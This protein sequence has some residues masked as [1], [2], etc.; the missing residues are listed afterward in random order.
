MQ[1]PNG[2]EEFEKI[3][4]DIERK[5]KS[6]YERRIHNTFTPDVEDAEDEPI[7]DINH[8]QVFIYREKQLVGFIRAHIKKD[9]LDLHINY[10]YVSAENQGKGYVGEMLSLLFEYLKSVGIQT[11]KTVSLDYYADS[12]AG[13]IAYDKGISRYGYKSN[14]IA[15]T[16][17]DLKE[18]GFVKKI[19]EKLFTN[20]MS[21]I[22]EQYIGK[23][24]KRKPVEAIEM[25]I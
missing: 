12:E 14:D 15:Y 6:A 13:W 1:K 22:Y 11:N 9:I 8:L 4:A 7:K 25:K 20:S 21:W 16:N 2:L 5:D 17:E 18:E 23:G 10:V 19:H 3:V 24:M